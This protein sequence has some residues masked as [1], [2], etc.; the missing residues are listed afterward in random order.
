MRQ[1]FC[2]GRYGHRRG[3]TGYFGFTLIELLVVLAL[4]AILAAM[5]A[6]SLSSFLA[7]SA[8]DAAAEALASDLRFARTEAL[9]RTNLVVLCSSSNGTSCFG[10]GGAWRDGWLVFVDADDDGSLSTGDTILRVQQA[11]PAVSSI[12]DD[13]AGDSW[14][15]T[16]QPTG[17]AKGA[18]QKFFIDPVGVV[19]VNGVVDRS[20][21][22]LLCISAT[23]RPSLRPR[24][25][26]S[27]AST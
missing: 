25:A 1:S 6:P 23:G 7:R 26:N 15:F 11:L 3:R 8:V 17:W 21:S 4:L 5:A 19:I 27:C 14:K 20:A 16:Y 9:K 24:G 12:A 2:S 18:S 13:P 10:K 22:R